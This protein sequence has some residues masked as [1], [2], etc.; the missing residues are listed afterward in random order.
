LLV[1]SKKISYSNIR[2]FKK[3]L[4][5]CTKEEAELKLILSE[6]SNAA[7]LKLVV[8]K[9]EQPYYDLNFIKNNKGNYS[10]VKSQNEIKREITKKETINTIKEIL[11]SLKGVKFRAFLG[12][13]ITEYDFKGSAMNYKAKSGDFEQ[14]YKFSNIYWDK[15]TSTA[16]KKENDLTLLTLSFLSVR[17][18]TNL[19]FS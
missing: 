19:Y 2:F 8:I 1:N 17:I 6:T 3:G 10:Y 18:Q 11:G 16:F 4:L 5:P 9:T 15:L 14:S 13:S 12:G 7:N